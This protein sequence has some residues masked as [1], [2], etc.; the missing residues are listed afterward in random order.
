M[1][2]RNQRILIYAELSMVG[3][4]VL[5]LPGGILIISKNTYDQAVQP[6]MKR[7]S[8]Y[9]NKEGMTE[10]A[11]ERFAKGAILW[12]LLLHGE[13]AAFVWS[14]TGKAFSPWYLPVTPH[15]GYILDAVTFEE[16]RGRGLYPL[17]MNYVLGKLKSEGISRMVGELYTTNTSSIRGL[18][19]TH[20]R[21]FGIATKFRIFGRNITIW[22]QG[23]ENRP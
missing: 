12:V 13:I 15:D 9:W 1:I 10:R 23:P 2:F 16:Y 18:E 14:M 5:N 6:D 22:S 7:I 4:S 8:D 20:Y 21:Q 11:K 3:D 19:K 17:L